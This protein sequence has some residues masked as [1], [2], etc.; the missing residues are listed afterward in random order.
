MPMELASL[1]GTLGGL[2]QIAASALGEDR[3][4]REPRPARAAGVGAPFPT[5]AAAPAERRRRRSAN[6]PPGGAAPWGG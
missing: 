6:A 2:S 1:A 3:A 4:V 5:R